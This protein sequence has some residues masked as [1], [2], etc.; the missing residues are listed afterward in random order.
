MSFCHF[1]GVS[2]VPV[3]ECTGG[4]ADPSGPI[5][6][7]CDTELLG[8]DYCPAC[9]MRLGDWP[10]KTLGQWNAENPHEVRAIREKLAEDWRA[11]RIERLG[12][13]RIAA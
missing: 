13:G 10:T 9:E 4:W 3:P 2:H 8:G 12:P 7:G 11:W 1:C 6:P 5:C